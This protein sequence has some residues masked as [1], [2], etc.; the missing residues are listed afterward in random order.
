[1]FDELILPSCKGRLRPIRESDVQ[2][3][4]RCANNVNVARYL[5]G[6]FPHPY[7]EADGRVF[8]E[9]CAAGSA[10]H[11]F[12]I[13]IAGQFGGTLSLRPDKRERQHVCHVGYW[14]AEP[15]WGRGIVSEAV[16]LSSERVLGD[17]GFLR[18]ETGVY[19]PNLASIRVLE[20]AGF[21]L[22]GRLRHAATYDGE[23][24]DDLLYAKLK[25]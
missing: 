13:E 14:L 11:V 22:E 23:L 25:A 17:L 1:M 4:V 24:I 3:L 5:M 19:A 15:F 18:M 2:D 16:M 7:T 21:V 6:A 8:L 9:R 10:G 20:K 12:A